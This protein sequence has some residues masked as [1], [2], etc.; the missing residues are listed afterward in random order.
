MGYVVMIF[1]CLFICVS[2]IH[3]HK[4][5]VLSCAWNMNGTWL[6]T[7]SRDYLVKVFDIRKMKEVESYNGHYREV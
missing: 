7:G 4:G 1:V 2:T 3:A 5:A 6:A